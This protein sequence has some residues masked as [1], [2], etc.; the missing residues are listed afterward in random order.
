MLRVRTE[1]EVWRVLTRALFLCLCSTVTVP[2]A[3]GSLTFVGPDPFE[4]RLSSYHPH[5]PGLLAVEVHSGLSAETST[6]SPRPRL[7]TRLTSRRDLAV[8][9]RLWS[10]QLAR[11]WYSPVLPTPYRVSPWGRSF[12]FRGGGDEGEAEGPIPA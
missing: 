5:P 9:A 6:S 10:C 12:H 2:I 4:L 7:R 8:G 3:G 1:V 11:P